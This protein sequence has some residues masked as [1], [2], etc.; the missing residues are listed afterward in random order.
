MDKRRYRGIALSAILVWLFYFF[1]LWLGL[2]LLG[3]LGT[4]A[5]VGLRM[6]FSEEFDGYSPGQFWSRCAL[7]GNLSILFAAIVSSG[8]LLLGL[9]SRR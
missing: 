7:I 8:L 4:E 6:L 3:M 5:Y 1:L 2:W 9:L